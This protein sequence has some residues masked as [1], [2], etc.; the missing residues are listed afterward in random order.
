MPLWAIIVLWVLISL[1]VG[2]A[3]GWYLRNV[4]G[5]DLREYVA[6]RSIVLPGDD[7]RYE[8]L[9]EKDG[10]FVSTG[11]LIPNGINPHVAVMQRSMAEGVS[12]SARVSA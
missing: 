5:R 6:P 9:R 3:A 10:E 1:P 8:F 4:A 7:V 11:E 12:Y 2:I